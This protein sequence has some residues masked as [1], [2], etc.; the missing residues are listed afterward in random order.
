[1]ASKIPLRPTGWMQTSL[2][3]DEQ[4][5]LTWYVISGCSRKDAFIKFARPDLAVSKNKAIVDSY[6]SQFYSRKDVKEYLEAYNSTLE[7]FL[8]PEPVVVKPTGTLEERKARART[9]AMEF[10]MSLAD[11][12][13]QAEDPET[14]LKLMDKVGLLEGEE[15]VEEA[16]RRYLP[17]SC[18]RCAYRQFCEDNT[19]DMCQYCRV[20]KF[21]EE[22]GVHYDKTELLDMSGT[23]LENKEEK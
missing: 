20:R 21:A 22:Q 11:N 2:N 14:V 10:A 13:D 1:M 3:Q 8:H 18:N 16:P 4:S 19:E 5:A 9:K 23:N 15:E 12:I 7:A 6:L 17:E